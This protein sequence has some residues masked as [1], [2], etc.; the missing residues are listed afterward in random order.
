M[1]KRIIK[2][3][4]NKHNTISPIPLRWIGDNID[5]S[6]FAFTDKGRG[7]FTYLGAPINAD[8]EL[9][10]ENLATYITKILDQAA[11]LEGCGLIIRLVDIKNNIVKVY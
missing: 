11:T 9:S 8:F 7:S 6:K 2:I 5:G 1:L 3:M 10:Y 4:N